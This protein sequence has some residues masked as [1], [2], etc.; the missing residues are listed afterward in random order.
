MDFE[1]MEIAFQVRRTIDEGLAICSFACAADGRLASGMSLVDAFA[2]LRELGARIVGVNCMNGAHAIMQLLQRVPAEYLLAGFPSAGY[3]K[4][5][6]GRF[7]YDATPDDFAQS[8][9][10]MVAEGVRLV[11]G[12]CGTNPQHIAAIA[13]AI[14]SLKP[15]RSKAR[16]P[17]MDVTQPFM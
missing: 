6:E 7:L 8:A 16:T 2:K 12:C 10:E 14:A 13:A 15:G 11:G 4:Y 5:H 1:E 3:P 17:R 9:R